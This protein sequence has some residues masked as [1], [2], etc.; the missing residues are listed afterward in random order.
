MRNPNRLALQ[1][2]DKVPYHRRTIL[3]KIEALINV[4]RR[5]NEYGYIISEEL[6]EK[7]DILWW[8][9]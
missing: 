9:I 5:I 1:W 4:V 2:Y 3:K 7:V 8:G 6:H